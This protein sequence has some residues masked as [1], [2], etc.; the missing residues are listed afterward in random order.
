[1]RRTYFIAKK[2]LI[3]ELRCPGAKDILESYISLPDQSKKPVS[4]SELFKLLLSSAQNANMKASVVGGSIGGIQN[5]ATALFSFNPKKVERTFMNDPERLLKHIIATV[6]PRGQIRTTSRSVWPRYFKTILSAATF[7]GQ[8]K[9]GEDFYD[10][11]NHFYGD[12]RSVAALPMV[13]AA[14][15][16]GIGYTLACDFL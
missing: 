8:F 10:W 16:D 7:F 2:F 5:L 3:R 14:E 9:S 11:A 12:K 6:K 15:I 13:L 4:V 1:M